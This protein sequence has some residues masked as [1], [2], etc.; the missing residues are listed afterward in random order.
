MKMIIYLLSAALITSNAFADKDCADSD[1]QQNGWIIHNSSDFES[2]YKETLEK[3]A[4][5]VSSAT[6]VQDIEG[7]FMTFNSSIAPELYVKVSTWDILATK[8]DIM[9]GD[10]AI[11]TDQFNPE[12]ALEVRWFDGKDKHIV[13]NAKYMQC[14]ITKQP[15]LP[16]TIFL[17]KPRH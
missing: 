15:S 2:I 3:I 12:R 16:N 5:G 17:T 4:Q 10:I 14:I 7:V 8:E 6:M 11:F 9:F 1:Y 13:T